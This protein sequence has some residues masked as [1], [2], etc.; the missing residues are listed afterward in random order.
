MAKA[1]AKLVKS[2]RT[3]REIH[4]TLGIF[5]AIF[6]FIISVTGILLAWKKDVNLLMPPTQKGATLE[7][8]EWQPVYSLTNAALLAVD[9]LGLKAENLDKIEYR[10]TKG[11]A[12]VIF[13]SGSWE[14]QV[15]AQT[16]EV[17]SVGRRHSDWIEKVHDGSII[18]DLFKV[19]SMNIVGIGLIVLTLSGVWLW[20]G[21]RKIR[22]LKS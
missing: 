3:Y 2:I 18:S 6:I 9:S 8:L 12:K 16:L 5:I 21:P 20:Y 4:K 19:I 22:K 15:D 11:I 14:V 17:Y 1:P 7:M 13:D 10:A